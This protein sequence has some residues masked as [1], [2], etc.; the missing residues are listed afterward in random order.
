MFHQLKPNFFINLDNI[1]FIDFN[2]KDREKNNIQIY[3]N[4]LY[5]VFNLSDK[6][7]ENLLN[8]LYLPINQLDT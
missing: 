4:N 3:S 5:V 8:A 7:K 6:E 2:Y 1:F